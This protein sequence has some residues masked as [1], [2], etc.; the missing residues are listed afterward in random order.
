MVKRTGAF[1]ATK[2]C[3]WCQKNFR[4][5]EWNRTKRWCSDRCRDNGKA[6]RRNHTATPRQIAQAREDQ[7]NVCYLCGCDLN[8]T[9]MFVDCDPK[10]K[11]F[12]AL[13]CKDCKRGVDAYRHLVVQ[14]GWAD[15]Q[16]KYCIPVPPKLSQY[17]M[18]A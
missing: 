9:R 12:K 11:Q 17:V 2:S 13:L 15:Y 1:L 16:R 4:V 6:C 10:I 5:Y 18:N 3:P 8:Q 7:K 14:P